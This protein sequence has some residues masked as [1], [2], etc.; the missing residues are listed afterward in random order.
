MND[1]AKYALVLVISV[2]AS[3][4]T[5]YAITINLNSNIQANGSQSNSNQQTTNLTETTKIFPINYT[6]YFSF[7][8][9]DASYVIVYSNVAMHNLTI[10]FRYKTWEGQTKT[11]SVNYGDY[12]PTRNPNHEV[13]SLNDNC[14]QYYKVPKV[15]QDSYEVIGKTP[16]IEI[17]EVYGYS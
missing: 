4:L 5:S 16:S 11:E 10:V 12:Y 14:Y 13:E 7:T 2:I 17:L 9:D 6:S 8:H 3:A 1:N 15:I